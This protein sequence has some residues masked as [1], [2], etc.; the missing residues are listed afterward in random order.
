[1]LL[2]GSVD[3]VEGEN[4]ITV[5]AILEGQQPATKAITVI[6]TPGG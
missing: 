1:M 4:S 5:V 3:L 2:V 6:Y